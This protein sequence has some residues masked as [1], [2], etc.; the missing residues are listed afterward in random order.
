MRLSAA[1]LEARLSWIQRRYDLL[2]GRPVRLH[3][4]MH[5]GKLYSISFV[6]K[7]RRDRRRTR[8][9]HEGKESIINEL[10]A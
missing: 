6:L 3:F 4:A 2:E 5:D 10:K 1:C 8:R 9:R 7:L